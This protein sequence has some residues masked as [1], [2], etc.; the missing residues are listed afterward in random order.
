M[1]IESINATVAR[2]FVIN[3]VREI[4]ANASL[5]LVSSLLHTSYVWASLTRTS[6]GPVLL[7]TNR[8]ETMHPDPMHCSAMYLVVDERG[9][10]REL[11][12]CDSQPT[13]KTQLW[14]AKGGKA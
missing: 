4:F 11:S 10:K 5:R 9:C 12:P 6:V 1:R 13:R 8:L 3:E 7:G 14:Q 2:F